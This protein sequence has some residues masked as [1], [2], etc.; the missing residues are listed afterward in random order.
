MKDSS[1]THLKL[2]SLERT[3]AAQGQYA[4]CKEKSLFYTTMQNQMDGKKA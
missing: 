1:F 3:L 4:N 2:V